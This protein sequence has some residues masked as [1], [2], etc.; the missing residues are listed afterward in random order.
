MKAEMTWNDV[1]QGQ[2]G[3]NEKSTWIWMKV[4][5]DKVMSPKRQLVRRG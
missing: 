2:M 4:I 3:A 1:L 5:A